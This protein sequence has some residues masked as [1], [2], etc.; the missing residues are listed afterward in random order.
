MAI[1]VITAIVLNF[2]LK[3]KKNAMM[4][5]KKNNNQMKAEKFQINTEQCGMEKQHQR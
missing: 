4:K 1:A 5:K 3:K 2:Q